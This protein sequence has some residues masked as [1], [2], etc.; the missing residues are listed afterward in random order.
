MLPFDNFFKRDSNGIVKKTQ[1]LIDWERD[2]VEKVRKVRDT[3][4]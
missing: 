3:A 2:R 4:V 1:K